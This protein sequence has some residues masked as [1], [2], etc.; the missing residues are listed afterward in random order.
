MTRTTQALLGGP[1]HVPRDSALAELRH[2]TFTTREAPGAEGRPVRNKR[3]DCTSKVAEHEQDH[4]R[5]RLL[6]RERSTPRVMG[7]ETGL[8][9]GAVA[10]TRF[11]GCE[12]LGKPQREVVELLSKRERDLAA[13][14]DERC[15]ARGPSTRVRVSRGAVREVGLEE[16]TRRRRPLFSGQSLSKDLKKRL[17]MLQTHER[18]IHPGVP[19][20]GGRTRVAA[21]ER[22]D[23]SVVADQRHQAPSGCAAAT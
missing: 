15:E 2:V 21:H 8:S 6:R 13:P 4:R 1:E 16:A 3:G 18:G 20:S 22:P 11:V 5:L 17:P 10:T 14:A 23:E 7:V 19:D 9:S 12:R